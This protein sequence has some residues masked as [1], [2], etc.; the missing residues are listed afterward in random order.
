VLNIV[1]GRI[2]IVLNNKSAKPVVGREDI[3]RTLKQA[4]AAE[5]A[6]DGSKPDEAGVRGEI[7][8]LT[9]PKSTI[10]RGA[11]E[12]ADILIGVR[13]D[14]DQKAAHHLPFGLGKAR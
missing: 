9:D 10:G 1:P 6:Y 14:K 8:V 11:R 7:L 3:E 13:G 5:I 2:V 12:I 4:I